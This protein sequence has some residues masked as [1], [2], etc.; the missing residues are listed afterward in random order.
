LVLTLNN[1]KDMK[2]RF[3]KLNNNAIAPKFNGVGDAGMD[4]YSD[5]DV[6]VEPSKVV[7]VPTGISMELPEGYVALVW[8][9]S[10]LAI[11]NG[12]K[13]M[14]GVIDSGFRGEVKVIMTNLSDK[15]L[16]LEKGSRVA[17]MIIQRYEVPEVE[18]VEDLSESERGDGGFG[19]SGV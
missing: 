11:K 7:A 18:L 2:I 16:K 9:R 4:I 10:G 13:T 6:L 3:K 15:E 12:I 19:S 17:Q 8:D 5:S 1:I 14:G